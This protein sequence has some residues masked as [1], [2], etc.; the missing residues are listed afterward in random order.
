[1]INCACCGVLWKKE[2]DI[3]YKNLGSKSH[4]F[5]SKYTLL[6]KFGLQ[7]IEL[8]FCN[9]CGNNLRHCTRITNDGILKIKN[10]NSK[11]WRK[12]EKV[13]VVV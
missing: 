7:R 8:Q 6:S 10:V 3:S 5:I 4:S 9:F 2:K 13:G 11:M 1:M 12:A